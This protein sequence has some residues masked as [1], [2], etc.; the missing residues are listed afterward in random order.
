MSKLKTKREAS[1]FEAL[2]PLLVLVFVLI[3][4]LYGVFIKK[5]KILSNIL[6]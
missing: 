2:I 3:P 5:P 4:P 6:T 1:L